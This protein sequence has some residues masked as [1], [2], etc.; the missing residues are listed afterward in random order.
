MRTMQWV[1]GVSLVLACGFATLFGAESKYVTMTDIPYVDEASRLSDEYIKERCVLDIY[2]W[3]NS[4]S[5]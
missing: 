5:C 4:F 2:Y 1:V 3:K